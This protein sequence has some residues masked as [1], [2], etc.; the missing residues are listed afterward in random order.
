MRATTCE[1][2]REALAI[3]TCN[4]VCDLCD[5]M[6]EREFDPIGPEQD[7]YIDICSCQIEHGEE[8]KTE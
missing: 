5:G 8:V 6:G 7:S 3:C 4:E 2:C 1:E